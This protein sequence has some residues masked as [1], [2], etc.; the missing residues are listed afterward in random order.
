[1]SPSSSP[2][3]VSSES[4][5]PAQRRGRGSVLLV[6][7]LM[8]FSMFFGAG[9]LIFPPMLGASAGT[10]TAPALL[11]FLTT[12]VVLPVLAILAIAVTGRDLQDLADR[13]GRVF[14]VVFTV[15]VYL[16][17]GA[18]YALPPEWK[19]A[20]A[21]RFMRTDAAGRL[22]H[23]PRGYSPGAGDEFAREAFSVQKE[24]WDPADPFFRSASAL[25]FACFKA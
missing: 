4:A 21:G 19:Q 3:S 20:L 11:G 14:G 15:M 7:S 2:T 23:A 10:N 24:D 9:N 18:F 1:M 17:I 22:R 16:S 6:A 13:G 8:L 5:R 12:G 25:C